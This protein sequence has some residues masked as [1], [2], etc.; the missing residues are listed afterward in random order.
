VDHALLATTAGTFSQ[1][2]DTAV[3]T[4]D[5]KLL[6]VPIAFI[7]TM[8][9]ELMHLRLAP[10]VDNLPGGEAAHEL[11]T[12][13][14]C[15]ISGFGLFQLAAAELLGWAGYLTAPSRAYALAVF[16]HRTG[17]KPED[18]AAH[19]SARNLKLVRQAARQLSTQG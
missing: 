18:A 9:H 2:E 12:D 8:V 6:R 10:F 11:A 14:H 5:P 17:R 3:V 15:I 13:L 4:Y 16:L 19:L 1:D 7:S